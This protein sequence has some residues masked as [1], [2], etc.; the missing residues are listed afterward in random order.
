MSPKYKAKL[1]GIIMREYGFASQ[2]FLV[3]YKYRRQISEYGRNNVKHIDS[4]SKLWDHMS[5]KG[6]IILRDGRE[7]FT[8]LINVLKKCNHEEL[9]QDI[10]DFIDEHKEAQRINVNGEWS[11][12]YCKPYLL[13]VV[14]AI[15]GTQLT[16]LHNDF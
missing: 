6:E 13:R 2:I 3:L 7:D 11:F 14:G 12:S 5:Q 10:L 4:I 16:A 15:L 9:A 1:K 8:K